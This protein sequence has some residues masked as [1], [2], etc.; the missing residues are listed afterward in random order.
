MQHIAKL[1]VRYKDKDA[2]EEGL[3]KITFTVQ[4]GETVS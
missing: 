4:G 1:Y 3:S 2:W